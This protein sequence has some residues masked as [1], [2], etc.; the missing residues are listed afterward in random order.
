MP[1]SSYLNWAKRAA[2]DPDAGL[3]ERIKEIFVDT[4]SIYGFRRIGLA[5]RD[6][7]LTVNHKKIRRIMKELKLVPRM[8]RSEKKYSSYKG[9][10]GKVAKNILARNFDV[11]EPDRGWASDVTEFKT[12]EGKVY[13]SPI[14]DF[15][16]GEII[17]YRYSASADMNLVMNM[18]RSAITAHPCIDGLV[19]H[20]DQG[21]Q[22]QHSSFVNCLKANGI[23]QSMS[24]KGNCIDNSKME[25]FFGH[26]KR[27]MY[28]G[29][30]FAT[31]KELYE[32]IDMYIKFYNEKRY[33]IKL[34]GLPPLEFR[35]QVS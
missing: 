11:K 34:K 15:C 23:V 2:D 35:K 22:Y 24:R 14:K 31:R 8:V 19:F 29:R 20:T 21:W 26:M 4:G 25:T 7:G 33:Q 28:Y 32:A 27:E 13:L 6:E 18:M 1:K 12:D 17:S 10:V 5:L 3:R 30:K 9:D 16:T